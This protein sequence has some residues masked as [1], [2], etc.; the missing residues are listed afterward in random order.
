MSAASPVLRLWSMQS[1]VWSMTSL[2]YRHDET[3]WL[4][5]HTPDTVM[6]AA[7]QNHT[8]AVPLLILSSSVCLRA[9]PCTWS[10]MR[11]PSPQTCWSTSPGCQQVGFEG[12]LLSACTLVNSFMYYVTH[13]HKYRHFGQCWDHK[14]GSIKTTYSSTLI[15]TKLKIKFYFFSVNPFI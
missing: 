7:N 8:G 10:A 3:C 5:P 11:T 13:V 12:S 6:T 9:M 4:S 15:L 14:F 2:L 1:C